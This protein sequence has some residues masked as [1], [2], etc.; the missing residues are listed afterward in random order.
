MTRQIIKNR[1]IVNDTWQ[2]LGDDDN[3]PD[4]TTD[5][6]VTVARWR[7]DRDALL[8]RNAKLGITIGG[9]VP[10]DEIVDDLTHFDLIAIRFPEFKDGRGYSYARLLRERYSFKE[11]IRAIGNVLRDQLFYMERCGINAFEVQEDRDIHD[12][13]KAFHEFTIRYQPAADGSATPM[14]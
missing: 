14:P 13:L 10:V 3:L 12:S 5:I 4:N 9:G 6:I 2:H 1:E 8:A 7:K 11:E